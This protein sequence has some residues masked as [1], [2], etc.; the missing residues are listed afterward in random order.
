MR[1]LVL[2]LLC[3]CGTLRFEYNGEKKNSFLPVR[4]HTKFAEFEGRREFFF[5]GAL[6]GD[7]VVDVSRYVKVSGFS[8]IANLELE[9]YQTWGDLTLTFFSLGFYIPKHYKVRFY[10]AY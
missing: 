10:G 2:L 7:Q 9:K 1:F 8:S 3:S 4:G 5:W 6:P